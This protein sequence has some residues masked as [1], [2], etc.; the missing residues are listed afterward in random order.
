MKN[1]VCI[2]DDDLKDLPDYYLDDVLLK[3]KRKLEREI[4]VFT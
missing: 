2:S 1:Y 3:R 4:V